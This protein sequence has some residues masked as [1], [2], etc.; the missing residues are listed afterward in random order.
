MAAFCLDTHEIPA[1]RGTYALLVFCPR[2]RN[3]RVGGLGAQ[4][5]SRGWYVYVGSAFGP[6]GLRARCRRHLRP[7]QRRHWHIDYLRPVASVQAIWFTSD[8]VPRE[9]Q[10]AE[11]IGGLEGASAPIQHFG[12]S[13][14]PCPSHLFRFS[15]R[16]SFS[17]FRYR[18]MRRLGAHGSMK[19]LS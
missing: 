3:L 15:S 12:S 17:G 2:S 7:L 8:P 9:H 6:G 4:R 1:C 19:S 14:C 5:L 16:P 18:A 13:D 10:W 11:I